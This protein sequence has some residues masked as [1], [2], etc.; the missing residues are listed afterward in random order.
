MFKV[1]LPNLARQG[2]RAALPTK[3]FYP[4]ISRQRAAKWRG[5]PDCPE[6]SAGSPLPLTLA[7]PVKAKAS[8]AFGGSLDGVCSSCPALCQFPSRQT[9]NPSERGTGAASRPVLRF[10]FPAPIGAPGNLRRGGAK[11]RKRRYICAAPPRQTAFPVS[12][13]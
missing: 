10:R 2:S 1:W 9:S 6:S 3:I 5:S 4:H 11:R 12:S 13:A 8:A 7:H